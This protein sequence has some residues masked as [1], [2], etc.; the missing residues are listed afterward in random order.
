VKRILFTSSGAVYGN[1][2]CDG[3]KESSLSS[4][5]SLK[6]ESSLSLGKA[7]AEFLLNRA[8]EETGLEVVIARCFSFVGPG[9]PLNLHYAIGNFVKN[10][11]DETPLIIKGDGKAIRSYMHLG[12]LIWWLLKLILDGDSGE[13][14][15]VGSNEPVS[16]LELAE[17]VK[18]ITKSDQKIV[19]HGVT[20]YSIGVPDRSIYVP[21]IEKILK[22][23]NLSITKDL[24]VSIKEFLFHNSS[25]EN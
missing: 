7:V 11:L 15:N 9:M 23:F 24:D 4:V 6:A 16:I 12:D 21:S 5:D 1:Q 20:Q 17:R 10:V 25:L 19:V 13:A 18:R 3:I 14:Y 8:F 2:I 22:R